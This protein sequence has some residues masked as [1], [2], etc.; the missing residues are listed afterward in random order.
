[1]WGWRGFG[2]DLEG[3]YEGETY[4]ANCCER[5]ELEDILDNRARRIYRRR[6]DKG[7]GRHELERGQLDG[8]NTEMYDPSN[9]KKIRS[10]AVE[11]RKT[12]G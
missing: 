1:M 4:R 10:T 3:G 2:E 7:G 11:E 5:C 8:M 12:Q 6:F 9:S